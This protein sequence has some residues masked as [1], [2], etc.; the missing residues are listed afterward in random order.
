MKSKIVIR[1]NSIFEIGFNTKQMKLTD[2]LPAFSLHRP[3]SGVKMMPAKA[4]KKGFFSPTLRAFTL[5]ELLIV[6]VIIGILVLLA[7]PSLMPLI[8]KTKATEAQLQLEHAYT[9]QKTHFYTYSK[10]SNDLE[11]IGFEQVKL[12]TEDGS[13]NY[14]IEVVEASPAAF[15]VR[16]T[17][18]VDFDGDG[19]LN[20]WEIDQD[21]K[22]VEVV[23]D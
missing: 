18:V 6:L 5:A 1:E 22:L 15:K 8:S 10:Y 13:A 20:I 3:K 17:A 23:K 19:Q 7:L 11:N 14:L 12:V 21:K 4:K 2:L 9:L 16:A